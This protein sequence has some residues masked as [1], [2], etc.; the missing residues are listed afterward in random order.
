VHG[1]L[2]FPE[3]YDEATKDDAHH[4]AVR[5]EYL[6]EALAREALMAALRVPAKFHEFK[7]RPTLEDAWLRGRFP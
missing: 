1:K 3:L 2:P 4:N 5:A 7:D 6:A